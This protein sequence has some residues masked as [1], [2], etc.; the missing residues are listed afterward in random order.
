MYCFWY[1]ITLLLTGLV[2]YTL[3]VE[4][5]GAFDA[6]FGETGSGLSIEIK[7]AAAGAA[8]DTFQLTGHAIAMEIADDS[9]IEARESG[10]AMA[11]TLAKHKVAD[12]K[13]DFSFITQEDNFLYK[14]SLREY[15]AVAY[16][17]CRFDG[18]GE[19]GD[20]RDNLRITLQGRLVHRV[21]WHERLF[22][23]KEQVTTVICSAPVPVPLSH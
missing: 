12:T 6:A 10:N 14:V 8:G 5:L 17:W 2:G 1:S 16:S 22:H 23:V 19:Q 15:I 4:L 3:Q 18:D 7:R 21:A 20:P 11:V 13:A 9:L